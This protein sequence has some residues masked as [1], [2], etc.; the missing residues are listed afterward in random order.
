VG[1]WLERFVA[2]DQSELPA[3]RV[4]FDN[5]A[6]DRK[7]PSASKCE[8]KFS[9]ELTVNAMDSLNSRGDEGASINCQKI[10]GIIRHILSHP[11]YLNLD[12]APGII[13]GTTVTDLRIGTPSGEDGLYTISGVISFSVRHIE[14]NG[15]LS[16]IPGEIYG[17]VI[18]ISETELGYKLEKI[19]T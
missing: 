7:N 12:F 3:I 10:L 8:S 5:S 2:F 6:Y 14:L 16:G 15:S 11:L 17:S 13:E 19:V 9:V 18:K 1:V 4:Y